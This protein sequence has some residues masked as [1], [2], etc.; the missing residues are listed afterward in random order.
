MHKISTITSTIRP[1][2]RWKQPKNK[3]N[4]ISQQQPKIITTFQRYILYSFTVNGH[5]RQITL[6]YVNTSCGGQFSKLRAN[7]NHCSNQMHETT[8]N[9]NTNI[10]SNHFESYVAIHLT[11]TPKRWSHLLSW[12]PFPALIF[13]RHSCAHQ[14]QIRPVTIII[15]RLGTLQHWKFYCE[16][17]MHHTEKPKAL[18]R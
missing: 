18:T 4:N 11:G 15:K 16:F 12:R 14:P 10:K 1:S 8:Y 9:F 2:S 5:K 7:K 6:T 3:S 17:E 13:R